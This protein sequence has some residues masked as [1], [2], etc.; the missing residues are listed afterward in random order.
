MDNGFAVGKIAFV[1][2]KSFSDFGFFNR[3][4]HCGFDKCRVARLNISYAQRFAPV[5]VFSRIK[6]NKV[7]QSVNAQLIEKS[8][9]FIS[10]TFYELY[11]V[12]TVIHN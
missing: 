3:C 8:G 2:R 6:V 4:N 10:Y 12:I 1:Q 7:L 5:N 9:S 11:A